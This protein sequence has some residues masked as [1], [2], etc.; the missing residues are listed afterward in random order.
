MAP[1]AA[2]QRETRTVAETGFRG[3]LGREE[4]EEE[5][6][7]RGKRGEGRGKKTRTEVG[8][9]REDEGKRL[10]RRKKTADA[11]SH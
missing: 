11:I 7:G 9:N 4:L 3:S 5:G 10:L 8:R 6:N 1:L 2:R